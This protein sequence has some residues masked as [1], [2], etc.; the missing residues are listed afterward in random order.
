MREYVADVVEMLVEEALAVFQQTPLAHYRAAAAYD[1]AQTAVGKM[2]VVAA[3]S[4]VYREVVHALLALLYQRVLVYLPVEF[5][6]IAIDL[7]QSLIDR[8][9]AHRNRTVA[10]YPLARLVYVS[11]CREV[12]ERV[13]APLAA[14]HGLLHLLVDARC[15]G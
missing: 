4:A 8:H 14:P 11:T 3:D 5:L 7:L 15:G 2:Y 9:C 6:H 10:D 12:H 1:S 13:A